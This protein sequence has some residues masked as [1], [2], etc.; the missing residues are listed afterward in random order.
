M[1]PAIPLMKSRVSLVIDDSVYW[2]NNDVK[3]KKNWK[4]VVVQ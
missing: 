1:Y 3:K 2:Y 4:T